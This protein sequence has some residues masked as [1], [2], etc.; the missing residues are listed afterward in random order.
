MIANNSFT[1]GVVYSESLPDED[2]HMK[3][4]KAELGIPVQPGSAS[5]MPLRFY[6]GPNHFNTLKQYEGI[7]LQELVNLGGYLSKWIN[8]YV[9]I[10]IFNFLNQSISNYGLIILFLTIIIKMALFPLTYK[11]YQSQAKMRVLKPQI[12]EINAKIPADKPM[13]RQQATMALYRKVGVN[14]M[15]GCLPM[16]LQMPILFAMFRFFP[17]SIELRQESFL[18]ARPFYLRFNF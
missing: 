15:G 18:W 17:T 1:N 11:S 6:F 4:M 7:E 14:P 9:I 10:P 13:E 5:S 2:A 8:K 12:D 16:L 3:R